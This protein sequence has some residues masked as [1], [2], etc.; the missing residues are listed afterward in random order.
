MLLLKTPSIINFQSSI[1][2]FV[3]LPTIFSIL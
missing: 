1:Q 3:A 2:I